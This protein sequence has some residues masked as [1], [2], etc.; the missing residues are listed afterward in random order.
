[1]RLGI[2]ATL[3]GRFASA[4]DDYESAIVEGK[5]YPWQSGLRVAYE[6]VRW[7]ATMLGRTEEAERYDSELVE[8]YRRSGMAWQAAAV[9]DDRQLLRAKKGACP[10]RAAALAGLPE[11]LGRRQAGVEMVR[12]A[13]APAWA[14]VAE[15][16]RGG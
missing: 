8:F 6:S 3:Q 5:S 14:S 4:L 10:D 12:P 7:L 9:D 16:L 15:E 13:T 1:V 11:R 2:I